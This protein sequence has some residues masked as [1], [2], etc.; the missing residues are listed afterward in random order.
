MIE[1]IQVPSIS[2]GHCK[3]AIETA[4]AVISGVSSVN[5]DVSA[6]QVCVDFDPAQVDLQQLQAV[7]EDQGHEVAG[8]GG[9][10]QPSRK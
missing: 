6:R 4:L 2:C 3:H 8:G 1:T 10:G 5:V 7:I 9:A